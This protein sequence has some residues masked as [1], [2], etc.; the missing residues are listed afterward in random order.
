MMSTPRAPIVAVSNRAHEVTSKLIKAGLLDA[1]TVSVFNREVYDW[2]FGKRKLSMRSNLASPAL[3]PP[4]AVAR[5]CGKSAEPREAAVLQSC[6]A[7]AVDRLRHLS[8]VQSV[9]QRNAPLE[10]GVGFRQLRTCRRTRPGQPCANSDF[11]ARCHR[12]DRVRCRFRRARGSHA[13]SVRNH[14]E[15]DR[16]VCLR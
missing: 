9:D 13:N 16:S 7:D 6:S 8:K 3:V 14:V 5:P 1:K 15:I 10:C 12:P 4:P 2:R 11:G